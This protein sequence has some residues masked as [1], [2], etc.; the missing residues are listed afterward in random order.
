VAKVYGQMNSILKTKHVLTSTT[1]NMLPC[2]DTN[3]SNISI[4]QSTVFC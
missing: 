2:V 1:N 4:L 3:K